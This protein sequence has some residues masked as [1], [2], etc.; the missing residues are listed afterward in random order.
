M[1]NGKSQVLRAQS[2]ATVPGKQYANFI[3][4]FVSLIWACYFFL[5]KQL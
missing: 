2:S 4:Q 3:P 1:N 5:L